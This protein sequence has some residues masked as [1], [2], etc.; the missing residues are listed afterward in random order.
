MSTTELSKYLTVAPSSVI[1][2]DKGATFLLSSQ[3]KE[4]TLTLR[5]Y[6]IL[7]LSDGSEIRVN[8][9][10]FAIQITPEYYTLG[11]EQS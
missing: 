1:V 4:A 6:Y 11:L 5:G 7:P 2:G 10:S 9:A 8:S 3:G